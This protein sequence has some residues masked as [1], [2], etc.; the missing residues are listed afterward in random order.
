[1]ARHKVWRIMVMDSDD[2][3][4]GVVSLSDLSGRDWSWRVAR[5]VQTLASV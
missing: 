3:L 4:V 2:T 5:T 1:M